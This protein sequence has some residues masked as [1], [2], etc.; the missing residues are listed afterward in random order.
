[1]VLVLIELLRYFNVKAARMSHRIAQIQSVIEHDLAMALHQKLSGS[2]GLVSISLIKV[3]P[4][5]RLV[6]IWLRVDSKDQESTIMELVERH[7]QAMQTEISKKHRF[8]FTPIFEFEIDKNPHS[9][10]RVQDL[11]DRL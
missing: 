3:Q 10:R 9:E 2:E 11:I 6:R 7:R 5:L 4:D 1:M 8:K